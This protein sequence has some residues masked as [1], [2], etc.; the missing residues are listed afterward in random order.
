MGGGG[1]G[2]E[3]ERER[4]ATPPSPFLRPRPPSPSSPSLLSPFLSH[5]FPP[6]ADQLSKCPPPRPRFIA[7][8]EPTPQDMAA[9]WLL[10]FPQRHK[11][12]RSTPTIYFP[13]ILSRKASSPR[14][15]AAPEKGRAAPTARERERESRAFVAFSHAPGTHARARAS[16][17]LSL[18]CAH[19][20]HPISSTPP[21]RNATQRHHHP[22]PTSFHHP[23][24][25]AVRTRPVPLGRQV[26]AQHRA[27][28]SQ[29]SQRK[30]G[31]P[32]Q[33][34]GRVQG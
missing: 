29:L 25:T 10:L 9:H 12:T 26:D 33:A 30:G 15:R 16:L 2:G 5:S 4:G 28:P 31:A 23:T 19:P 7:P 17:S 13:T 18:S 8:S 3:R 21:Q 1:G 20:S 32:Q 34:R 11:R 6:L 24:T 14:E 27:M 22:P